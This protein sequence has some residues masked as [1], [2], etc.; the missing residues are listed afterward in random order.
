LREV[1][2]TRAR[3][4]AGSSCTIK[5]MVRK[6]GSAS[7]TD[8]GTI[9]LTNKGTGGSVY[10]LPYTLSPGDRLKIMVGEDRSSTGCQSLDGSLFVEMSK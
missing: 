5:A 4:S 3:T 1:R 9:T 8:I 6:S 7:D 2:F 10:G